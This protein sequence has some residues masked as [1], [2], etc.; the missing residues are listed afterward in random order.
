MPTGNGIVAGEL[1]SDRPTI[2]PARP[3]GDTDQDQDDLHEADTIGEGGQAS[4]VARTQ[5]KATDETDGARPGRARRLSWKRILAYGVLPALTLMLAV[6][7]GYLKWQTASER[8]VQEAQIQS[9]QAATDSV[10]AMLSYRTESVEKD[11][12]AARDRL[13]GSFR[14]AYT[15]LINDVVI[16]GSKERKI[17]AVARVPAAASM[18]ATDNHAVVLV[19]VN[20]TVL[21]GS[22]PPSDS[23]S[24]VRV[25]LDSVGGRWLISQFEPV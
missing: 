14:D 17:S 8:Q 21:F 12:S 16:P 4:V 1:P 3:E 2:D 15:N 25:T 24:S 23:V 7:A 11:L 13:T 9:V 18:S 6:G 19:F 20:Q 10:I 5:D 22:D